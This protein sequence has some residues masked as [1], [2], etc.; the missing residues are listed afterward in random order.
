MGRRECNTPDRKGGEVKDRYDL[1][2][3][4]GERLV[5]VRKDLKDRHREHCLCHSCEKFKPES[6]DKNCS[7]ANLVYAL[8]VVE[9][10]VLP[11]WECPVFMRKE[12][13]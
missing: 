6:R 10:L 11:V 9:N 1:Y 7:I 5:W 13:K 12:K 2:L 8:C 4:H 3:H